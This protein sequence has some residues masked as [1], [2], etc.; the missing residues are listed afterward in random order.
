MK[1]FLNHFCAGLLL[2][3]VLALAAETGQDAAKDKEAPKAAETAKTTEVAKAP[4]RELVQARIFEAAM[5]AMLASGDS[6]AM[7]LASKYARK[8]KASDGTADP[9]KDEE[10][11]DRQEAVLVKALEIATPPSEMTEYQVVAY[12]E[13]LPKTK[14]CLDQNRTLTYA[15]R[16]L[17]NATGF[18]TAAAHQFSTG[19]N[20]IA[21]I[22]LESA[23]KTT[24]S[25][26][27]YPRALSIAQRY[28]R[29][30][31]DPDAL[32]GDRETVIE[33]IGRDVSMPPYPRLAQM[34]NPNA[35]GKLPDGRYALCRKVSNLL[36]EQG[37]T[38]REHDLALGILM[39]LANG[40]KDTDL[41]KTYQ[42]RLKARRES[43]AHVWTK[44]AVFPPQTAADAKFYAR[45]VDDIIE[46]GEVKAYE[47][48]LQRAGKKLEDFLPK[49]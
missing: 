7:A 2:L 9:G 45:F 34:C 5:T 16:H 23:A 46:Q 35:E 11:N 39:R 48:A 24:R 3:P 43:V 28:V 40:E 41:A 17:D 19:F 42:D 10:A 36:L 37:K 31:E 38:V 29:A 32:P 12:C 18:I 30:V 25:E 27:Y 4:A 15:N 49:A 20:E 14:L 21:Q 26:W 22:M 44:L 33:R 47:L 6:D 8:D 13:V 1:P